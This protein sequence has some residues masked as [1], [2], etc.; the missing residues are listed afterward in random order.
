MD[1]VYISSFEFNYLFAIQ[2]AHVPSLIWTVLF[3]FSC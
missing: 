1:A 3:Y 2:F